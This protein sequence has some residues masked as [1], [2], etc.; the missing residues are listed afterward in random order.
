MMNVEGSSYGFFKILSKNLPIITEE[1][2]KKSVR[3]ARV[4]TKNRTRHIPNMK[5]AY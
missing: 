5:S 2:H 3:V 4:L 1:S